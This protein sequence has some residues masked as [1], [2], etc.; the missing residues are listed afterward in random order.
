MEVTQARDCIKRASPNRIFSVHFLVSSACAC[1][2]THRDRKTEIQRNTVMQDMKEE[3]N[4]KTDT[5]ENTISND[6][7]EKDNKLN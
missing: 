4:K 1:T 3:C 5:E 6:A 7:S 2:R